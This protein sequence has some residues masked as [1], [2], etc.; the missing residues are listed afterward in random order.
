M[1]SLLAAEW[2]EDSCKTHEDAHLGPVWHGD[3]RELDGQLDLKDAPLLLWASP[4]CQAFST[5][6][7]RRGAI[8][9]RNGW[10]WTLDIIDRMEKKGVRPTWIICENVPGLTYHK[11]D[12]TRDEDGDPTE[13]PGCY[14]ERWIIPEFEKRYEHV[15]VRVLDAADFGVPQ[16]RRRV[17]LVA[18]PKPFQW[19]E[20]T[21]S[22]QSLVYAKWVDGNYWKKHGIPKPKK[23]PRPGELKE[24][25]VEMLFGGMREGIQP[26]VTVRDVLG[27]GHPDATFMSQ[28]APDPKHPVKSVDEPATGI[29]SGGDGHDSPHYWVQAPKD[30]NQ[31]PEEFSTAGLRIMM[32][33]GP[34]QA[35]SHSQGGAPSPTYDAG[36]RPSRTIRGGR[37]PEVWVEPDE[38]PPD[39]RG[40]QKAS[41]DDPSPTIRAGGNVDASGK[42]GG[43][44]P[45][46]LAEEND[47]EETE[48]LNIFGIFGNGNEPSPKPYEGPRYMEKAGT[49]PDLVDEPSR[50]VTA[51]DGKGA[52]P[53]PERRMRAS[54]DLLLST[55]RRRLTVDECAVLQGFPNGYPFH[56]NATSRYRQVGNAVAPPVA[57][58]LGKAIIATTKG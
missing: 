25:G 27:L 15:Q 45:P 58:T 7:K 52:G 18:G 35:G 54:D 12:C 29:R 42:L 16:R 49:R 37:A 46:Y 28:R 39:A 33:D 36:D 17:F 56:G 40:T 3:V 1:R 55:G 47:T 57:E 11:G 50:C 8:D 30:T 31:P 23:G 20:P 48:E 41:P 21:H 26:W 9:E 22:F 2:D 14:W 38:T 19:P 6:G 44:A 10:P 43:G 24:M 5:A 13:C 32:T 4:P 53:H 34:R 51:S